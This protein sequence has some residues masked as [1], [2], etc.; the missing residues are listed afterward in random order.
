VP[1][2]NLKMRHQEYEI[3]I[4][5]SDQYNHLYIW[6]KA[7]NQYLVMLHLDVLINAIYISR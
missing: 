3:K 4:N 6:Q 1:L 7:T 5:A 2:R